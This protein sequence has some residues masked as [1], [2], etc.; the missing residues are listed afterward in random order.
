MLYSHVIRRSIVWV[1]Y[2]SISS[3]YE[4]PSDIGS[5]G[6]AVYGYDRL[7]MHPVDPP[8]PDYVPGLEE[9]EQAPL[10]SDYVSGLEYPEYLTSSD[11]EVPVEDQPYAAA[12]SPIALSMGYIAD[13]DSEE[14]PEDESE[15][16]PTDCPADGGDA[17]DD[18]DEDEEE[19]SKVDEDEEEEEEK[20]ASADFTTA[21]SLVVDPIPSTEETEPFETDEFA[22][23]PPSGTPPILTIPLPISSLPLYLP[24]N[25][26]RA[27]VPEAVLPPR[28]RLCIAPGPRFEVKE[29][30]SA[31]AARSTRGFRAD[32]GFVGT[33]EAE[34]RRDLDRE[35]TN[36]I[37]VRLDDA[38]S[39]RSLMTGQHNVLRRDRRYHA[40][41][42]LLVEERLGLPE[43]HGH[44]LWMPTI[45]NIM[46]RQRQRTE[47]SDRLT[48]Q[49]QHKHDRF[50]EFQRT[51][52][53]APED[54]TSSS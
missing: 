37:Y 49:I 42:A 17:D 26:H 2:T 38:K 10:L 24:S 35:D 19:A 18:D 23:I 4:E 47:D 46:R 11:E 33:L 30:S 7:P 54:S 48:Q 14:D 52:D 31:A 25:D 28:K 5:P 44:S 1:T 6:V 50:R 27:D 15:D 51:R 32:Y 40:N 53:A 21:A 29:C 36:E 45:G 16:G 3:D 43:R 34:I 12:N 22:A 9:P 39:D 41:N 20:L 13:L 8:S